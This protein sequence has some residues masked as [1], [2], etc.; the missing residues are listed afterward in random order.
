M[1][2]I[3]IWEIYTYKFTFYLS[4]LHTVIVDAPII[5]DD[6]I[7]TEDGFMDSRGWYRHGDDAQN[8]LHLSLNF[9]KETI[10]DQVR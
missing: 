2:R 10:K 4:V 9:I 3:N 7:E 8:T 1:Y 5:V 6:P